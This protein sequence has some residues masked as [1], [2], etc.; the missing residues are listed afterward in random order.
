MKKRLVIFVMILFSILITACS[1]APKVANEKM[2]QDIKGYKLPV[3][4]SRSTAVVYVIRPKYKMLGILIP[5]KISVDDV[6]RKLNNGE[7]LAYIVK[8]GTHTLVA[9]SENTKK[10]EF[11]AKAKQVYF[12]ETDPHIGWLFARISLESVDSH[13]GVYQV[14]KIHNAGGDITPVNVKKEL[15]QRKKEEQ[16]KKKEQSK[17]NSGQNKKK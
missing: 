11:K 15:A 7:V 1:S 2:M 8:P 16:S 5:F 4:P 13:Y 14:K 6:S 9:K 17:K 10:V 3:L 12:Y